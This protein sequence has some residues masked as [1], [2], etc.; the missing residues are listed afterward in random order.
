VLDMADAQPGQHTYSISARDVQLPR[1]LTLIRAIPSEVRFVF[2]PRKDATVPV[3]VRFSVMP[4]KYQVTPP[5]LTIEG[6]ES[7]VSRIKA[8]TTDQIDTRG[9]TGTGTFHV[10]TFVE[11]PHVRIQPD[12]EVTVEVWMKGK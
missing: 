12:P 2:E 1:G 10:N 3:E 9:L 11:D 4:E 8:V 6:P 5:S 7:R